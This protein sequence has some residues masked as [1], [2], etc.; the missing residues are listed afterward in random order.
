[1][2]DATSAALAAIRAEDLAGLD[3]NEILHHQ[4]HRLADQ[5]HALPGTER[6][7]QLGC[8]RLRHAIGGTS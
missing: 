4:P 2:R 8:D 3:F 7:K 5:V 1:M 6:L